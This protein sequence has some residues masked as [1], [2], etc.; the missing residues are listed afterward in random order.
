MVKPQ[1]R[2]ESLD[3]IGESYVHLSVSFNV[4]VDWRREDSEASILRIELEILG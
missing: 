2:G 4:K 1:V 3:V